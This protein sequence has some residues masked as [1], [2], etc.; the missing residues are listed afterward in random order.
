MNEWMIDC[1]CLSQ[2]IMLT[3]NF[4]VFFQKHVED[5]LKGLFYNKATEHYYYQAPEL[6]TG[7]ELLY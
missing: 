3:E 6:Q 2:P 5:P 7:I 4:E 1:E